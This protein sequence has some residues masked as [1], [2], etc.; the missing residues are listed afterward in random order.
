MESSPCRWIAEEKHWSGKH[1]STGTCNLSPNLASGIAVSSK[2]A[3][4]SETLGLGLSSKGQGEPAPLS[5]GVIEEASVGKSD[6]D[7]RACV[8][9]HSHSDV[10]TS[11]PSKAS[12]SKEKK[13]SSAPSVLCEVG[14]VES[15]IVS[16]F[17]ESE[18]QR[19]TSQKVCSTLSEGRMAGMFL[20]WNPTSFSPSQVWNSYGP[21]HPLLPSPLTPPPPPFLPVRLLMS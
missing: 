4:V 20:N 7:K 3:W 17:L 6:W 16:Q 13:P 15:P 12:V 9:F 1:I 14:V 5:S 18:E 8:A 2:G 11:S 19:N 10:S 21:V